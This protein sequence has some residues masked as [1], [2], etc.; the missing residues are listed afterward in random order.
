M[1]TNLEHLELAKFYR[2]IQQEIRSAQLSE[3]EGGSSEQLFTEIAVMLLADAGET[4]NAR[5]SYDEKVLK[6]GVQHKINAYALS[7]NYETLDLFITIYNGTDDISRVLKDEIEKA[8]RRITGFFKNAVYKDYVNEIEEA[9]EIFDLAHTLSD[10]KELKEGLVRVNAFIL[11]DGVCSSDNLPGHSIDRH[12]IYYRIIDLNYLYNIS[13][14]SHMPI[15]INFKE[16]GF[17]VPCIYSP[18]D[19]AEYQSYLA[20][21]SG[22]ALVNIYERFGSRLLEQNVR[23]F[24]QFTGK[25]NKGIRKTIMTEPH[26]FLAFNNGLA[27]TAEEIQLEPL[28]DGTGSAVAWVKDLQIVNGGQTTAS[29]YHTWKKDKADVSGIFVQLKLNV[30]KNKEKFSSVVARIAEY[31]N[32]QNKISASDLSS[33]GVNHVLLEKLSRTIW[34]PPVLGKSQQ[35]R[36]FYDRARGQ[37]KT[38]MLKEGFTQAK[39]RAFELKNPKSQVLTK[40]DLAKYINT[41]Q[42][43]YD[44][45]KLV[46]GPHFVV[47][48]NQ[49]NYVQFMHHNFSSTPDNIYFE[50]AVAKAILFRA[51]EKVYGVKPNAIGDMRYITVPYTIAWLGY[52][53]NYK[54]DLYKIWKAQDIST[55]LRDK[56]REIMLHVESYI[57]VHAPGSLYGEWAKKED[58]WNAIRRQDFA[59][60]FDS[61]RDELEVRGQG[62]NR[63][64]ISNEDVVSAEIKAMQDRLQSVHPKTWEKIEEWGRAT[65]K[66][67]PYQRTMA[68]AIG[69]NFSRNRKLS[70]IEFSNGQQILDFAIEEASEIFFDM[71][72]YFEADT[73]NVPA[74]KPEITL[75]LIKA[76]VKWDKRSKKLK[77]FEYRFMADLAEAKKPLTEYHMS[78]ALK[79][80]EK[81]KRCGFQ[82]D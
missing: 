6:T 16:D 15:E 63:T 68:R 71:E 12:P 18:S 64:R 10:S 72:E 55:G 24:L 13:E 60:S 23:S 70:E 82:E 76:I 40:E 51:A 54:L 30:V 3:E 49:K 57:K 35:T 36:W 2:N 81:A 46:I 56:L 9:S 1:S 52:R 44:G 14:K 69:T 47:R 26:M 7:D 59:I 80:Y 22:S 19:N 11:T 43:V 33:N 62:V 4:E 66:L 67:S 41:Y 73:V 21:I 45:K 29:I 28:P 50:D 61:I 37:Y 8:G 65:G 42:E 34:A 78:L 38:A 5:I 20:I 58:C 25:I 17:H 74:V 53:L 27:A 32:T 48:G 77:D 75:E 79:N 39:R 31:A